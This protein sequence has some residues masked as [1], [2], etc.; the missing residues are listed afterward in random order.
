MYAMAL[1][2]SAVPEY[3]TFGFLKSAAACRAGL[4]SYAPAREDSET[5]PFSTRVGDYDPDDAAIRMIQKPCTKDEHESSDGCGDER[6]AKHRANWRGYYVFGQPGA[7]QYISDGN[8]DHGAAHGGPHG[9]AAL[10]EAVAV[11][12]ESSLARHDAAHVGED[13]PVERRRDALGRGKVR[14]ALEAAA[15]VD[16]IGLQTVH[17]L[18]AV[19]LRR[20]ADPIDG[21]AHGPTLQ[22]GRELVDREAAREVAQPRVEAERF[23]AVGQR[24]GRGALAAAAVRRGRRHARCGG[25]EANNRSDDH[26]TNTCSAKGDKLPFELLAPPSAEDELEMA[27]SAGRA[28][29]PIT[30]DVAYTGK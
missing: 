20:E 7:T 26:R 18:D 1:P 25:D 21:R 28:A 16:A 11:R 29:V 15:V 12:P 10:G 4:R 13:G 9:L 27:K 14:R 5:N 24:S 23:V 19:V 2:G 17:G 22:P 8:P 3:L 30:P 6:N